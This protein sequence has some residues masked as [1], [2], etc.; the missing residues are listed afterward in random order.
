MYWASVIALVMA[1][2][3]LGITSFRNSAWYGAKQK[4]FEGLNPIDM[5]LAKIAALFFVASIYII[6][7]Y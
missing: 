1:V 4:L 3:C 2:I 5:K 7:P 6:L